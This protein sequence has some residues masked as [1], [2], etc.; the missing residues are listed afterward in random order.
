MQELEAAEIAAESSLLLTGGQCFWVFT[1]LLFSAFV[2]IKVPLSLLLC[3]TQ[4]LW[5]KQRMFAF[6][7]G[8]SLEEVME[9]VRTITA[10]FLRTSLNEKC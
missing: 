2:Q 5:K 8:E 1:V 7:L 6:F 4:L 9:Q 10:L 3:Y